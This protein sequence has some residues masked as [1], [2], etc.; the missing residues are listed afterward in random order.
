MRPVS[1]PVDVGARDDDEPRFLAIA[2]AVSE[3]IASGRLRPG[4]A[5]PGSRALDESAGDPA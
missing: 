5:M 2:R 3:A 1:F 4:A